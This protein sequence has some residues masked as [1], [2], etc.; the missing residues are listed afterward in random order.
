MLK[1]AVV[2]PYY[3]ESP[4]V[5]RK[6]HESVLAQ[7]HK[8]DHFLVADGHPSPLF[9]NHPHHIILPHANGDNG[10]TPRAIGGLLA[11]SQGYDAVAY[12][13]ADNWYEPTHIANLVAAQERH[14]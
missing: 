3:K 5:L 2:T 14:G 8:C 4:E 10:N 7:T 11:E 6:C 13:D 1:V 9:A 12:L